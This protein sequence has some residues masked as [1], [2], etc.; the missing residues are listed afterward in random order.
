MPIERN[1]SE[2]RWRLRLARASE[3]LDLL[4]DVPGLDL[5]QATLQFQAGVSRRW[6][7]PVTAALPL[8]DQID[9]SRLNSEMPAILEL[10]IAHGPPLLQSEAQ[11]LKETSEEAFIPLLQAGLSSNSS[12][13][14][15]VP[16]FFVRACLQPVAE[17]LQLQLAKDAHYVGSV[18]P[19]C[20]GLPQM[21]VLRPEGEGASRSLLCSFCLCEWSFRRVICPWCGEEDKERLPRYSSEEWTHVHIEA[22]D[23]CKHYLKAVDLSVNGLAVPLVDEAALAVLDVW[24]SERGYVKIIPNLIGF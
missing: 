6:Q 2:E 19:A 7:Q 18:C 3:L 10:S 17:N 21:A 22:C 13:H 14:D 24:A 15:G 8:R 5:Y 4:P 20:G 12:S 9:V 1:E 23:T 16:A 11:K